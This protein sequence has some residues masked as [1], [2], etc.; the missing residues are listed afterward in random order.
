MSA[1]RSELMRSSR[2][3]DEHLTPDGVTITSARQR[4]KIMDANGIDFLE[5]KDRRVKKRGPGNAPIFFDMGR[6]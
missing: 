3:F 1:L 2:T 5:D 6:R 4:R